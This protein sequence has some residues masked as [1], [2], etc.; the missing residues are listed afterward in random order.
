M[1]NQ[2]SANLTPTNNKSTLSGIG[3]LLWLY[4]EYGYFSMQELPLKEYARV[5]V[6]QFLNAYI[7]RRFGQGLP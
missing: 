6:R 3:V 1:T 4:G 2:H 7:S 5:R